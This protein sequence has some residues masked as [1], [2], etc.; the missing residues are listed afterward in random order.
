[1]FMSSWK[2]TVAFMGY[3]YEYFSRIHVENEFFSF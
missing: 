1:M 3:S 2:I